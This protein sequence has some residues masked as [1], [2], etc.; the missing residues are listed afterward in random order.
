MSCDASKQQCRQRIL[1][2]HHV[3]RCHVAASQ[4]RREAHISV[5]NGVDL[6][7]HLVVAPHIVLVADGYEVGSSP[8]ARRLEIQ[9]KPHVRAVDVDMEV[10]MSLRVVAQYLDSRVGGAVV[11][12]DDLAQRVGLRKDGV[13]LS[14]Q[15]F[16]T[17]VGTHHHSD[18]LFIVVI[19]HFALFFSS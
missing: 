3:C 10:G 11:L 9:V 7:R 16:L 14:A 8:H 5:A 2:R 4:M 13:E 19:C 12:H 1:R 17:V 18:G 6:H 15:I